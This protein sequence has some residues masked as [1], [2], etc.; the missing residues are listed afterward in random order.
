VGVIYDPTARFQPEFVG[1]RCINSG[2]LVL[3]FF[4][5]TAD[6]PLG[7]QYSF[8]TDDENM[9]LFAIMQDGTQKSLSSLCNTEASV[10][11]RRV[12]DLVGDKWTLL[13]IAM[14]G[15]GPRRFTELK[16]EIG[17]ISQ[18]MLTLTLRQLERNGLVQRTVYPVVP[19]RVD[20]Q[21]TDLGTTVR[22]AIQGIVDWTLDHLPEIATARTEFEARVTAQA[23]LVGV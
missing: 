6:F 11:V 12:L 16:R 21:L 14:L 23:E 20:Y 10:E 8:V 1:D 19:P 5:L 9:V 13:V 22:S 2:H 3:Q 4:S 7:S 18:R 17:T 15:A